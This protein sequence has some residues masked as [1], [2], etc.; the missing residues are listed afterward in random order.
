M[1]NDQY[2][3]TCYLCNATNN[4]TPV[5]DLAS[6]LHIRSHTVQNFIVP[7]TSSA[8]VT[9]RR[10]VTNDWTVFVSVYRIYYVSNDNI[11]MRICVLISK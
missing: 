2:I 11:F 10:P 4:L 7:V 3:V 5:L 6:L 9:S 1:P 8:I